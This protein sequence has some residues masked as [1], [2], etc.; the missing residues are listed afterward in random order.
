MK[1]TLLLLLFFCMSLSLMLG[2]SSKQEILTNYSQN[3]DAMQKINIELATPDRMINNDIDFTALN[4]QEKENVS[5][6][7]AC[8]DIFMNFDANSAFYQ[9]VVGGDPLF[10][11]ASCGPLHITPTN[12][13]VTGDLLLFDVTPGYTY[14]FTTC[15]LANFDTYIRIWEAEAGAGFPLLAQNDDDFS[16][17]PSIFHSTL[18]WTNDVCATQIWLGVS[19]WPCTITGRLPYD[20][21]MQCIPGQIITCTDCPNDPLDDI[22]GD[23]V[24][25][26]VDNCP[27]TA[28]PNQE[29]GDNDGIGDACDVCPNDPLNDIDGDGVCG[30]EDNCPTDA[31]ADQSDIDGDGI[32]D[33]CDAC[34]NDPL[35]D[36]DG[37][38]VCGDEDNCP[39]DANTEQVDSDC[40]T[41]GDACDVCDGGDDTVDANGDGFAD[42]SQ[43]LDYDAY[44][45]DW[46][47]GNNKIMVC[48]NSNN[49][50]T[51]CIN[52]NALPAHFNNHNDYVGPCTSCGERTSST[53]SSFRNSGSLVI[54]PNPA[55]DQIMVSMQLDE[56]INELV[57]LN[58]SG[59]VVWRSTVDQQVQSMQIDISD[60]TF[61][62]GVYFIKAISSTES[63]T[64]KLVI[65][66]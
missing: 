25:G 53:T 21:L 1:K 11:G 18:T 26:D 42:C 32:G 8:D 58:L 34:P 43:L 54:S 44:S 17:G 12:V 20:M 50:H 27:F 45:E 10:Q 52:K 56:P 47:C 51:I 16:C 65:L 35:N 14:A 38:G 19:Q 29:D 22:D 15:G 5:Q 3:P 55:S 13:L 60:R 23:D 30:D 66:K 57:I 46:Y 33:V 41:V 59:Q 48:H 40:D 36:I 4:A 9:M 7:M 37:D 2:Q 62:S 49:P 61:T 6:R 39:D 24:C 64:Q 63:V 28:N 31:N